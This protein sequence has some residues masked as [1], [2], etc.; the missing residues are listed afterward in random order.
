M[1]RVLWCV[2]AVATL[3]IQPGVRTQTAPAAAAAPPIVGVWTLD[4]DLSDHPEAGAEPDGGPSGERRGGGGRG[5][6]GGGRF[7]GGFGGGARGGGG[8]A[9]DRDQV[10]R[11][12]EAMRDLM[13]PADR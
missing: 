7:G 11:Q 8:R 13:R 1:T 6:F 2:V 10:Q 4:R 9:G 3:A 5:G 12:M